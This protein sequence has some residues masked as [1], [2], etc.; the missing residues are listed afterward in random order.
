MLLVAV[1][2]VVPTSLV[3]ISA[4][5]SKGIAYVAANAGLVAKTLAAQLLG[6]AL[7]AAITND[8]LSASATGRIHR[9]T[10]L[11]G[12]TEVDKEPTQEVY[13]S[14]RLKSGAEVMGYYHGVTTDYDPS[15]REL[16]LQPPLKIRVANANAVVSVADVWRRVLIPGS[17]IEYISVRYVKVR[18]LK[19]PSNKMIA[20]ARRFPGTA[21]SIW[22]KPWVRIV[23]RLAGLCG[24]LVLAATV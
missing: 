16:V 24:V 23:A 17:E 9:G 4:L 6:S 10:A 20:R 11:Y 7:L 8:F 14:V 1:K 18:D 5:L 2:Q 3:D 21:A 15:K 19:P 13:L 22:T 12:L